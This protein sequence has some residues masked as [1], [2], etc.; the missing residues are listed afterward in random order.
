MGHDY[1]RARWTSPRRR[2]SARSRRSHARWPTRRSRRTR[3]RG[4]ATTR[5]RGRVHEAR[6]ARPD[7]RLRAGGARR[8]G[9]GLPLVHPRARRAVARRRRR[10]RHRGGAHRAP[11]R[12]R[13][14]RSAPRSRTAIRAGAGG[15]RRARRVRAHRA[16]SG[17]DAG[18]L[19]PAAVADGDGWRVSGAKQW[20][21]NGSHA[22]TFLVFAR[23]DPSTDG[24]PGGQ[25][26]PRRRQPTSR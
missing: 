6:R 19:R 9:R 5:S 12:S 26:V 4:I 2:S 1:T 25:R 18:S 14:S 17:S 23:T 24:A 3:P 8:S 20:I 21:T 7:G 10:R 22:G 16:G 11:R 13:S 15:G